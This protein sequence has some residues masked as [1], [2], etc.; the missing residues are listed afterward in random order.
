MPLHLT[1]IAR[2]N[3][4]FT[5]QNRYLQ[6]FYF[7]KVATHR[8]NFR[9]YTTLS[10]SSDC[11]DSLPKGFEVYEQPEFG[12]V[13]L[14]KKIRSHI[15]EE[16]IGL[17]HQ[18]LVGIPSIKQ[19]IIDRHSKGFTIYTTDI[20]WEYLEENFPEK[21]EKYQDRPQQLLRKVQRYDARFLF[22]L[23][24]EM[25]RIFSL[26]RRSYVG[27]RESWVLIEKSCPL[28]DLLPRYCRFLGTDRFFR[29]PAMQ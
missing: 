16:E 15:R 8:G 24:H 14:R 22:T 12:H 18:S 11:V 5:Y 29:L 21:T 17:V 26:H 27:F 25:L 20:D 23:E 10:L 6:T 4:A 3:M 9:Y 1:W 28:A 19:Y 2:K 13:Y 7:K